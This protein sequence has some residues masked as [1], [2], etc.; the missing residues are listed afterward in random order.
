MREQVREVMRFFH[1]ATRTEA[2]YWQWIV[3]FLR[4]HKPPTASGPAAWRHPRELG[5][6]E[7][8]TFLTHLA[9]AQRVA[10]STQ[11]Q[12]LNALVF[13]YGQ[14]LHQPLG[15]IGE[16]A[17]VQRPPRLPEVLSRGVA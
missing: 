6:E 8:R 3:R 13:L 17:R 5:A 12:A 16:F 14:V 7:V 15:E 2:T 4:F 11:N 9:T 1:Y 10:A